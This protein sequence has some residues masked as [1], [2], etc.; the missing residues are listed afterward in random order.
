M[1][2]LKIISK[3]LT[4]VNKL[5]LSILKKHFLNLR[6]SFREAKIQHFRGACINYMLQSK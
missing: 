1:S 3:Q 6:S 5:N 2:Y 4:G